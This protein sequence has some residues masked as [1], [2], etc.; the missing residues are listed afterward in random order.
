MRLTLTAFICCFLLLSCT[1]EPGGQLGPEA[2]LPYLVGESAEFPL[3]DFPRESTYVEVDNPSIATAEIVRQPQEPL[4]L[5]VDPLAAG[6]TTLRL[7]E[8]NR[9]LETIE[10][11]VLSID[12]IVVDPLFFN[13]TV[14]EAVRL[15]ADAFADDDA[16]LLLG[17]RLFLSI[18]GLDGDDEQRAFLGDA[19]LAFERGIE[20]QSCDGDPG[21]LID[22][23]CLIG[24][25]A[26]V[27][28]ISAGFAGGA[29]LTTQVRVVDRADV[30]S[31]ELFTREAETTAEGCNAGLVAAL[32]YDDEGRVVAG[33]NP[34]FTLNGVEIANVGGTGSWNRAYGVD[35]ELDST[36]MAGFESLDESIDVHGYLCE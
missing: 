21:G 27:H 2:R 23:Q 15:D 34:T 16:A 12:R 9:V 13:G 20:Q 29:T 24:V 1:S 32:G 14:P 31:F 6:E 36:I 3:T 28:M 22:P 7:K 18:S 17:R 4:L 33:L 19:D 25:S 5:V 30:V 26:G 10:I 35:L 8:A 11:V